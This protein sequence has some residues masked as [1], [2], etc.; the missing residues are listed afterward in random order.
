MKRK[1]FNI[2]LMMVFIGIIFL[3]NYIILVIG[4]LNYYNY[5]NSS[6]HVNNLT[7]ENNQLK[8]ELDEIRSVNNLDKYISY[9][10]LKSELLLRD[11]YNFH[12]TIVI[13]YGKDKNIKEG[14]AV[15]S[16]NGLLG[17]ISKVNKK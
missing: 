1:L 3:A 4:K 16:E 8:K 7:A 13:K 15:V 10:Y 9:D 5:Q 17:I 14:M 12:E 6:M 2:G 11:I